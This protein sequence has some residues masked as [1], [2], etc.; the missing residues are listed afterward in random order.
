MGPHTPGPARLPHR[1]ARPGVGPA[2]EL[3]VHGGGRCVVQRA[4]VAR[5]GLRHV[6][7]HEAVVAGG[8]LCVHPRRGVRTRALCDRPRGEPVDG[9]GGI[10]GS[11]FPVLC[12]GR[13]LGGGCR[14][15]G[16]GVGR[17]AVPVPAHP[18]H[19]P[20]LPGHYRGTPRSVV[21]G[22]AWSG[23]TPQGSGTPCRRVLH[24]PGVPVAGDQE[25]RRV[26]TPVRHDVVRECARVRQRALL[27]TRRSRGDPAVPT[28][29][30]TAAL[31]AARRRTRPQLAGAHLV[32]A[33]PG[34]RGPAG[35]GRRVGL[36]SDLHRQPDLRRPV[37]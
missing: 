7:L 9:A 17:P 13:G 1:R 25:R 35:A 5:R 16:S 29:Q 11:G 20:L 28:A 22:G 3:P 21:R 31:R 10:P 26:R 33:G 23:R 14:R 24:G 6:Q 8:P 12:R 27:G 19:S 4:P 15:P 30:A 2:G 36:P 18:A 32:A 34:A 37:Q